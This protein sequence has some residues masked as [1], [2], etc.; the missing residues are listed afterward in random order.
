MKYI[1]LIENGGSK[2]ADD[3]GS[4]LVNGVIMISLL[5]LKIILK[6]IYNSQRKNKE[7]HNRDGGLGIG[8]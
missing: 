5:L 7:N 8:Y 6:L 2:R 4:S 1:Q 3:P